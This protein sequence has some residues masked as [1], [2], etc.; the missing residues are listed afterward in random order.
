MA[1]SIY[2]KYQSTPETCEK[3]KAKV[4]STGIGGTVYI[5]AVKCQALNKQHPSTLNKAI[6][7]S[8]QY[9][10]LLDT[11]ERLLQ[12]HKLKKMLQLEANN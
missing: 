3:M 7:E 8:K 1:A 2:G 4:I 9:Q 12:K 11:K 10:R 6:N 5:A